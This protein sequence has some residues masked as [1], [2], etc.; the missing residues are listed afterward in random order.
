MQFLWNNEP[1]ESRYESI[2]T[3][4]KNS[5]GVTREINHWNIYSM[6]KRKKR[7]PSV[8]YVNLN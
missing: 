4:R 7:M 5:T 3:A 1:H 8:M 2:T 6:Y